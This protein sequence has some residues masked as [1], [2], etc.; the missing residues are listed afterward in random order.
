MLMVVVDQVDL[1]EDELD[2]APESW[3]VRI[4]EDEKHATILWGFGRKRDAEIV[5][6]WLMSLPVNWLAPSR[7]MWRQ[8]KAA[9]YP[10]RDSLMRAALERLQW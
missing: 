1:G 8:C 4:T 7:T 6:E 3:I 10:D 9:G 5:R 2:L